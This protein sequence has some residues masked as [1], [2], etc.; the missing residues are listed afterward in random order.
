MRDAG[1]STES[2]YRVPNTALNI[3]TLHPSILT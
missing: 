1:L 3:N 2:E